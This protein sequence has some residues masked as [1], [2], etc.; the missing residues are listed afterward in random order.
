VEMMGQAFLRT[1]Y[2]QLRNKRK[3]K[4][5]FNYNLGK[6]VGVPKRFER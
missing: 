4:K 2:G 1:I 6:S 3:T 5:K